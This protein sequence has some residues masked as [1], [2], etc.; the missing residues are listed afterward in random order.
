[1][2]GTARY[3]DGEL[4]VVRAGQRRRRVPG[5]WTAAGS[6]SPVTTS[7]SRAGRRTCSWS[8]SRSTSSGARWPSGC[9]SSACWTAP[10]AAGP[11]SRSRSSAAPTCPSTRAGT[12]WSALLAQVPVVTAALGPV[13]GLGAVRL[14][15]SHVSV[16]VRE[17]SQVFVAGPA[18]VEAGMGESLDKEQLGG[19]QVAARAGT[20]DLV[21]DSEAEALD[22]VRR[23]LALP[24]GQ[25]LAAPAGGRERGPGGPARRGAAGARPALA[26]LARTTCGA[27]LR[28]V[29]DEG[30]VL[31]LGRLHAAGTVT[32]LARLGGRPVAV[33][34]SDPKVY[35]G[36]MTAARRR[37][38]GP[39]R[40]PRRHLPP[41]RRA[42][43]R[44]ARLR[45][46][47]R[48]RGGSRRAARRPRAD[49]PWSRAGCRGRRC[50]CAGASAWPVLGTARSGG[51]RTASR[52]P[53]ATGGRCRSRAG[54][55]WRSSGSWPRARTPQALKDEIA[56]R[57]EAVRS[58]FR[59]A[60][61]YLVEEVVDPADTRPLLCDWAASAYDV[62]STLPAGPVGRGLR[63]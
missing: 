16:M 55:R 49:A 46:R 21:A 31:E 4:A 54:W 8:P 23:V 19:W 40:R 18:V 35:G 5:A 6:S 30:S 34:A 37:Q 32:A 41:A 48:L 53:R 27:L 56:A 12:R 28:S 11:S 50:W 33:L 10:A 26:P 38:A 52:G 63:P 47:L 22:L 29:F 7:P 45:H 3:E 9:R 15:T 17:L 42:P 20:V 62:L 44:P 39:L 2:A 1:M 36:G 13:A 58:P 59:T 61:S 60:E 25:R 43:G 24:A 51:G 57:L 14:V